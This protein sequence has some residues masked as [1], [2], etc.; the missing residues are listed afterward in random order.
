M[1]LIVNIER[2]SK[3]MDDFDNLEIEVRE[4]QTCLCKWLR[5]K[6][7]GICDKIIK[8]SEDKN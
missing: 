7:K 6:I 1:K 3:L 8:A 2:E 4:K 5:E